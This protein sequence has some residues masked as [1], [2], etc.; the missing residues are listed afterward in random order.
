[1]GASGN[2]LADCLR[3]RAR[4]EQLDRV[5]R[6]VVD[7]HLTPA[8]AL[9]DLAAQRRARLAEPRDHC[10]EVVELELDA[11]PATGLRRTAIAHR[12][13]RATCARPVQ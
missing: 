11:V 5:A 7:E 12:L 8:V 4:L 9:D 1:M 10:I 3:T 6:G 13:A 2:E